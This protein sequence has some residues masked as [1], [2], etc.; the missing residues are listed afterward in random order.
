MSTLTAAL[1]SRAR[2]L[3]RGGAGRSLLRGGAFVFASTLAWHASNFVFNAAT[4]R[5]LGPSGYSELA[6]TVTL[7][8]VASP[9]LTS[10]Q[11][12]TSREVTSLQVAGE[13]DRIRP[14][15][16]ARARR[17]AAVGLLAALA[18]AGM[19]HEAAHFLH[20]TSGWPIVIV[21]GGLCVSA[22]THCQRGALQGEST[23]RRSPHRRDLPER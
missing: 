2:V 8:Y 6:A 1:A 7:L 11:T 22:I 19:S 14:A 12:M 13:S 21:C 5:L 18:C 23:R 16:A 3:P 15:V 17:I 10:I 20:L 9:L 4:A